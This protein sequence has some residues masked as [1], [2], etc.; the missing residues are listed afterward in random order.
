MFT[1][2]ASCVRQRAISN[3]FPSSQTTTVRTRTNTYRFFVSSHRVAW[4]ESC[5]PWRMHCISCLHACAAAFRF[6]E[7][8]TKVSHVCG[9]S[10]FVTSAT[11]VTS[12]VH[13]CSAKPSH[14]PSRLVL[15]K[16]GDAFCERPVVTKIE[17]ASLQDLVWF[18][19]EATNEGSTTTSLLHTM[20]CFPIT[21]R[22]MESVVEADPEGWCLEEAW[23]SCPAHLVD[24]SSL[25]SN[26]SVDR[27]DDSS[28]IPR[29]TRAFP[30]RIR[31][32]D[33]A[34]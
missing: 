33:V 8:R 5:L 19:A 23:R 14:L 15:T 6:N 7:F 10:R 34:S 29:S 31:G 17:M 28:V 20:S 18:C 2:N 9:A 3:P 25:Q 26:R 11:S 13:E 12:D 32:V 16:R 1:R 30:L 21:M 24:R 4:R 27:L 22:E